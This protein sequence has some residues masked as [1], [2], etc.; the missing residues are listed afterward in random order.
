MIRDARLRRGVILAA[1]FGVVLA[2]AVAGLF[3][4]PA[5]QADNAVKETAAPKALASGQAVPGDTTA[6]NGVGNTAPVNAPQ[7]APDARPA[8]EPA[9]AP[10]SSDASGDDGAIATEDGTESQPILVN[11]E[12]ALPADY[13]PTDL[14]DVK[15]PFSFS[16]DSPRRMMRDE[17]ASALEGLVAAAEQEGVIL[18]GVSGYRS[19]ETQEAVFASHV[20]RLGSEEAANQVSAYPGESEHQTGLAMDISSPSVGYQLTQALGETRE[21][22]WLADNAARFG[23]IIRYPKG[24]ENVTEYQYEPWHLRYVGVE[25]A[26]QIA[27]RGLT[28]E[29]YLGAVA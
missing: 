3:L 10:D 5:A 15:I 22:R 12:H 27:E 2:G 17:A 19:Y 13:A 16:E 24:K 4:V 1:A 23:F 8:A 9:P 29:E 6:G 28:L 20:Q 11:K 14:R 21:G 26:S 7:P 25:H 18:A